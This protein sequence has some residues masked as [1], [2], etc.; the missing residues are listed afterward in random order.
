MEADKKCDFECINN[1]PV[2]NSFAE[3]GTY[4]PLC[5]ITNEGFNTTMCWLF[6]TVGL[7]CLTVIVLLLIFTY[8]LLPVL[9]G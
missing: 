7:V 8:C 6:L 2:D 1:Q 9:V 4:F 5:R 3:G